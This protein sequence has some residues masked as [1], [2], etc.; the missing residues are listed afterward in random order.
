LNFPPNRIIHFPGNL[1]RE[2]GDASPLHGYLVE[3]GPPLDAVLNDLLAHL[4][5]NGEFNG[6]DSLAEFAC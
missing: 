5:S 4:K 1:L 2:Y 6:V 3:A